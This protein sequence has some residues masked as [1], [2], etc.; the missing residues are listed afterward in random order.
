MVELI[1]FK[2]IK[3]LFCEH[4]YGCKGVWRCT[5]KYTERD[6]EKPVPIHFFECSK[7]G[8]RKIIKESDCLYNSNILNMAKLWL[9]GELEVDFSDSNK[10][11]VRR[12]DEDY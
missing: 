10:I 1:M 8:K 2:L 5:F 3:Q 11:Q 12:Y 6:K 7:C 4:R 9:K